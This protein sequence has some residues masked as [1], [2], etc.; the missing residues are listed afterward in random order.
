MPPMISNKWGRASPGGRITGAG[1]G[2]RQRRI[3]WRACEA[4]DHITIK[5]RS[6]RHDVERRL[7]WNHCLQSRGAKKCALLGLKDATALSKE[8][9]GN[10]GY[11]ANDC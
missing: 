7:R 11:V 1:G 3:S 6:R 5:K 9:L 2:R 4:L 8:A 10:Q